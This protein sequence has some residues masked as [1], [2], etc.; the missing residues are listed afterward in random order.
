MSHTRWKPAREKK[1]VEE[2][3]ESPEV[4]AERAEIRLAMASPKPSTTAE[5]N[6]G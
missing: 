4:A 3:A 6:R 5:W 1:L 2:C